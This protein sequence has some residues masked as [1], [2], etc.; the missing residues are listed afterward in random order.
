[1]AATFIAFRLI[2]RAGRRKL[3]IGGF[4]GMAISALQ[5]HATVVTQKCLAEGFGLTVAEAMWKSKPMAA[6]AVGGMQDQITRRP[7]RAAH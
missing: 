5:Q 3:A 6:S 4:T 7:G 1:M 2:D